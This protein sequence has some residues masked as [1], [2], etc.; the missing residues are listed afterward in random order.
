M[1]WYMV[2]AL[3][4]GDYYLATNIV[5]TSSKDACIKLVEDTIH[6]DLTHTYFCLEGDKKGPFKVDFDLRYKK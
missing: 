5:K 6:N 3:S 4:I 1:I 2:V